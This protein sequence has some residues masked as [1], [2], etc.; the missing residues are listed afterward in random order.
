MRKL[1]IIPSYNEEKNLDWVIKNIIE[2]AKEYDYIII[3]DCSTDK[4]CSY[5]RNKN[6]NII[7]L[8][9]NLGIGGC[10]QTGYKYA[11]EYN[12]DIVVQMDGDGQHNAKFIHEME[13]KIK[14]TKS[15]MII[16]SRYINLKGFQ[17]TAFRRMGGNILKR[18]IL[19]VS[20]NKISDPTS[21]F[22]MIT[23][24][25]IEQFCKYY[26]QD[27]PEPESIVNVLRLGFKV[28][29]IPVEMNERM[30]GESSINIHK[31]VYYMMKVSLAI[32]IDSLK[33]K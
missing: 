7:N 16:G 19:L 8:P 3:N 31:S 23:K 29:E 12:Y 18:I 20:H 4:T 30:G 6:Y 14:S 26:P 21:G 28:D 9:V 5:C 10:V 13:E 1:I 11:Y 24:P 17:S 25:I 2:Y 33:K 32:L 22:R 27:Y 15:E